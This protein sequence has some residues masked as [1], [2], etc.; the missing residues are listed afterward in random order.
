MHQEAQKKIGEQGNEIGQFRTFVTQV[1]PYFERDPEGNT[2]FS[3][4]MMKAYAENKLGYV[5]KDS[6]QT[7]TATPTPA[8]PT[9]EADALMGEFEQNPK[10]TMRTLIKEVMKEEVTP[11]ISSL[12]ER[13]N[14]NQAAEVLAKFR[15]QIG[16][17]EFTKWKDKMAKHKDE[18]GIPIDESTADSAAKGLLNLYISTKGAHGELLDKSQAESQMAEL[19]KSLSVLGGSPVSGPADM[20]EASTAQLLGLGGQTT[21]HDE[22]ASA[23]F[24]KPSHML[25]P[26]K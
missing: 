10:E 3:E 18:Y 23:L 24:G 9:K 22:A 16:E 17:P 8:D 1:A 5:P 15:S 14:S 7:P 25:N 4:S 26:G 2:V 6:V 12:A 20:A 11:N 19:N 13:V 21:E